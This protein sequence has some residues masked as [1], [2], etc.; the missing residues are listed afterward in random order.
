MLNTP[1]STHLMR[2]LDA[3]LNSKSNIP[4]ATRLRFDFHARVYRNFL[5][6]YVFALARHVCRL[7]LSLFPLHEIAAK[8][9]KVNKS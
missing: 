1:Q 4:F 7:V 6:V 5:C 3:N 2:G 9:V 8:A